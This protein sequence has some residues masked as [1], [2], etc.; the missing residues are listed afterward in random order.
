[1]PKYQYI[2]GIQSFAN[3]DSGASIVKADR[4]GEV[5]DYVAISEER[6]VRKK[7]PYTFPLH[8]IDYC[9]KYFGI[10]DIMDINLLV[11]DWIRR[12]QW[13]FSGA[14]FNIGE[15]DYLKNIFRFPKE[16]VRVI[17]HHLAHAAST[18]Y[19]SGF[20][21]SAI[22][23]VDGNGSD[24]ETT[25]YFE[26]K[27]F[28]I[29]PIKN[30]KYYGLGALYNI[31]STRILGMGTGGEGKTMGLAPY[32][33]KFKHLG[34]KFPYFTKGIV[35]D[36]SKFMQRMPY[37]DVLNQI[38]PS[39]RV[40]PINVPYKKIKNKND[41]LKPYFSGTAYNL[42]DTLEK[43]II[44]ISSDLHNH[45]KSD[46]LCIAGGV[47]LNSVA[48]KKI[49]D[50]TKFK[51]IF[52]FPA[53]SD[54]GIPF[55]LAIWG[56]YNLKELNI[57]R[58]KK[59]IFK[60]AYLGNE[61]SNKDI[62]ETLDKYNIA[63]QKSSLKKVAKLISEKKIVGWVQGRSE[64]GPRSLGNRSILADSRGKDTKDILNKRVK[65]RES[66]RPFAP[67]ILEENCNQYFE[68]NVPSPYM[69][70]IAKVKKNTIPAVTHVDNTA[71]VQTVTKDTNAKFYNLIKEFK[72]ITNVPCILNTSFNDAGDPIVETPEDALYTLMKC[73]M[74]HLYIGDFLIDRKKVLDINKMKKISSDIKNNVDAKRDKIIKKYFKNYSNK[75][76]IN[77]INYHNKNSTKYLLYTAKNNLEKKLEDWKKQR[78]KIFVIGEKEKVKFLSKNFD[79]YK[80]INVRQFI[81]I[82]NYTNNIDKMLKMIHNKLKKQEFDEILIAS[83]QYDF[84]IEGLCSKNKLKYY[85]IY[86]STDRN[87][88][89]IFKNKFIEKFEKGIL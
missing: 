42:Q 70:L 17:S 36:F 18:Y 50:K 77:F 43:V 8:S 51:N 2:L 7:H 24:L 69:L 20:K 86:N 14:T 61:Y 3:M 38:N 87:L 16:R 54:S 62:K 49:L 85:K 41:V 57:K 78:K 13:E 28:K 80:K 40:D 59:L 25:S 29:N 71:R 4:N 79:N 23:I 27:N 73:D 33:K 53:C 26:G 81:N 44:K 9:M 56:Y 22:L 83:F 65:H 31:V 64:Y 72:K 37:S 46:N 58:Y 39:Y 1:M 45:T 47:G 35:N 55:G 52:I 89:N 21:K 60:N 34:L 11:C 30:F 10:K 5:L 88:E 32:G 67:S 84:Y 15:F 63:Y 66:Y 68:L 19:T 75:E 12:E 76:K 48:N 6:L 82:D 74:D